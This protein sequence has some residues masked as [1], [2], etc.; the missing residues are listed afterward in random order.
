[1]KRRMVLRPVGHHPTGRSTICC[2]L[3]TTTSEDTGGG[4]G[5]DR[6]PRPGRAAGVT[7]T[8]YARVESVPEA[9]SVPLRHGPAGRRDALLLGALECL[10]DDLLGGLAVAPVRALDVLAGLE[11]LVALEEVL[12]LLEGELVD[13]ADVLD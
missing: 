10:A 6:P 9:G 3:T 11:V 12:D 8:A 7:H 13:V 1:M 4:A 5:D 2:S